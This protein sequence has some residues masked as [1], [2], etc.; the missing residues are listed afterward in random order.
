MGKS[1][2]KGCFSCAEC[3]KSLSKGQE[4]GASGLEAEIYCDRCHQKRAVGSPLVPSSR[5]ISNPSTASPSGSPSVTI[6]KTNPLESIEKKT[7]ALKKASLVA[8][9]LSSMSIGGGSAGCAACGKSVGF[10]DKISGPGGKKYHKACFACASCEKPLRMGAFKESQ[11][12]PYC[13]TCH[14]ELS[15]VSGFKKKENAV[16]SEAVDRS[17]ESETKRKV[18]QSQST[19]SDAAEAL[20]L[21]VLAAEAHEAEELAAVAEEGGN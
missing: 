10:A 8:P 15:G 16:R 3:A 4:R 13:A 21:A 6:R 11:G 18:T 5:K 7:S 14:A 1:Y 12:Q 20:R 2:H 9:S 17:N 19:M